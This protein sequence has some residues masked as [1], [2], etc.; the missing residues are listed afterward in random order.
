MFLCVPHFG[1]INKIVPDFLHNK[2]NQPHS[3][4]KV[5]L[6]SANEKEDGAGHPH[7]TPPTMRTSQTTMVK[8][9]SFTFPQRPK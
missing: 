5:F 2:K 3:N 7:L 1:R 9:L 4:L 8:E 6:A